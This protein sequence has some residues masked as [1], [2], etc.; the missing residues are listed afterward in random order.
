[1]NNLTLNERNLVDKDG[2]RIGVFLSMQE[3]RSLLNR[4]E[5]LESFKSAREEVN[6]VDQIL[7]SASQERRDED[8]PIFKRW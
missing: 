4:L 2:N 1:M 8:V 7:A 3:Y 5:E 6:I